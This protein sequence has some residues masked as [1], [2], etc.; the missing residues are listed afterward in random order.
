ML[1]R[2]KVGEPKNVLYTGGSGNPSANGPPSSVL[3][4]QPNPTS[5]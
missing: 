5:Y 3:T 2:F 1:G 4:I